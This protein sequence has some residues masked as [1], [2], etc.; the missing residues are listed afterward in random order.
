MRTR[1]YITTDV[2]CAEERLVRGRIRAP[3]GYEMMMWGRFANQRRELGIGLIMDQL[4]RHGFRGTFFV[5]ALCAGVFGVEGLRDACIALRSRGH[6]VQLHLHPNMKRPEWRATGG[7]PLPDNIGDYRVD[8][9]TVLLR[10]G[11]AT[12]LACGVPRDEMNSF[13]AGNYG[14][15]NSTWQALRN[16][17]LLVDSSLNLCYLGLDCA[18]EWPTPEVDLFEADAG[19]WELPVTNFE[20]GERH[21]HLEVTAISVAEMVHALQRSRVSGV[22]HVTIVTHP[23]EFFMIDSVERRLGRPNRINIG[24]L[25]RL[26]EYLAGHSQQFD[27]CTVGQLGNDVR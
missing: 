17:G 21:R 25:R 15:A 5:E 2:E 14:A 13:R 6:D 27:V 19:I 9:Q 4:E 3:V 7:E 20:V 23:G 8:E 24:R 1:V 16:V 22:E 18:I 11:L 12:L 26:L 10:E